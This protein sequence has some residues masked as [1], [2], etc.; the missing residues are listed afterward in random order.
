MDNTGFSALHLAARYNRKNV[1]NV[2]LDNGA[3]INLKG[4]KGLGSE[5]SSSEGLTPLHLATKYVMIFLKH[6]FNDTV[7]SVLS[8][9]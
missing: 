1:I 9:R 3:D 7:E 6:I 5:G 2:L 8:L 4:S